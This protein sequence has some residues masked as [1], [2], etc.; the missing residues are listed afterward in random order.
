MAAF[1]A[2]QECAGAAPARC[3]AERFAA[4]EAASG[5]SRMRG[6]QLS[7][8]IGHQ[9]RGSRL[10]PRATFVA[11]LSPRERDA[12]ANLAVVQKMVGHESVT[13]TAGYERRG[14]AAKRKAADLVHV[15]FFPRQS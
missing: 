5:G 2:W 6:S 11:P 14:D 7:C 8:A 3:L 9:S 1:G 10:S 4:A 12:G 13:T 15:P